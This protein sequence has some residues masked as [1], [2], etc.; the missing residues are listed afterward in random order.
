MRVRVVRCASVLL[1]TVGFMLAGCGGG[2]GGGGS[3][4][5]NPPTQPPPPPPSGGGNPNLEPTFAS[6]QQHV[7]TPICTAC[8]VGASA[9]E[10]L[11]LDEANS[12]ALL[13]GIA[14]AQQPGVL[15]VAPGDPTGSYL[16]QKLEGT[17]A[18]G[19]RMPLGGTPLPQADIDVIRQWIVDGAQNTPPPTTDEPIRVTSLTPL[20]DETLAELPAAITAVFDRDPDASTVNATT[21][22]VERSGGDGTFGDG[23]EVAIAAASIAV[24]AANPSTAVFDLAGVPSEADTYR[25]R[26][27]GGGAGGIL[28]LSGHALDGEFTGAF[29]SG[30]GTEG[31]D[32]EATFEIAVPAPTLQEIQT[33]VF[34][35]RCSGCHTGPTSNV[36][37]A[38]MDL[39]S[40]S[41]SHASLVG[42]A[43]IEVPASLRVAPG[44]PNASYLI[45]KLEDP[46]PPVGSQMPLLP[47]LLDQATIDMIRQWIEAGA[48][49]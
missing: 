9:P 29:P 4:S 31:G 25:V 49:P 10:G 21:F 47:P 5:P 1:A 48:N 24:P 15:R 20:P 32:F 22:L 30:D 8:H 34:T 23:N 37:P 28:D 45:T 6:I 19:G 36:L 43:S 27:L 35:P 38:G 2:G 26:L 13:V 17:A 18:V 44:D 14:S 42:V 16:I 46:T 39:S 41:A 12:Y 40:A 33:S 11:R 3:A 7:F